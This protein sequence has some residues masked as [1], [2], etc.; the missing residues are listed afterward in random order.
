MTEAFC[1]R[2]RKMVTMQNEH[3]VQYSNKRWAKKGTCPECGGK[4][5]KT[6]PKKKNLIERLFPTPKPKKDKESEGEGAP[7]PE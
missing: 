1:V 2:C 5:A 3:E 6:I 4:V 7:A